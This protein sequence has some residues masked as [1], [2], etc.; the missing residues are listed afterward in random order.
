VFWRYAGARTFELVFQAKFV[1]VL[2]M[3]VLHW[4]DQRV[5]SWS[6]WMWEF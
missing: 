5:L 2:L 3:V 6:H 4:W 1:P